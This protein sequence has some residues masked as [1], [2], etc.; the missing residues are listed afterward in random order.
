LGRFSKEEIF[1]MK[2][3]KSQA[4]KAFFT[5][6]NRRNAE[7]KQSNHLVVLVYLVLGVLATETSLKIIDWSQ[8][9]IDME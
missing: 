2:A 9:K 5:Q 3:T 7:K 8:N 4:K 1:S 6:S